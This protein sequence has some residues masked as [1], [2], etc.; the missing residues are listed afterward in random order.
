MVSYGPENGPTITNK[1]L[2]HKDRRTQSYDCACGARTVTDVTV[3]G[4][5]Y[6]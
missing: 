1:R 5:S 6:S 2:E 4:T 3:G